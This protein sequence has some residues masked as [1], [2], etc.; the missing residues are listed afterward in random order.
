MCTYTLLRNVVLSRTRFKV[1][2]GVKY[3]PYWCIKHTPGEGLAGGYCRPRFTPAVRL[4]GGAGRRPPAPWRSGSGHPRPA[5]LAWRMVCQLDVIKFRASTN[6]LAHCHGP[7]PLDAASAEAQLQINYLQGI[8]MGQIL[9]GDGSFPFVA[10]MVGDDIIVSNVRSTWFGGPDDPTDNGET[11]SGISTVENPDLQGCALP[12]DGFNTPKTNGSP[13]PRLPW[14][15]P[16]RVTDRSSGT[17]GTFELIDLGPSKFAPSHAAIDLTEAA[18]RAL[19]ADPHVGV[20]GVDYVIVGGAKYL[21]STTQQSRS[22]F[23]SER[24]ISSQVSLAGAVADGHGHTNVKPP[25]RQFISSP[26]FSSRNGASIDMIVMHFTDGPTAQGAISRFLNPAE[27]VSAHYIIDR[28][29]SIYQMVRDSDKA[30]HAKAA[31]RTSIGIEHVSMPSWG[32]ASAQEASSIALVNWL[33]ATYR[34]P[35]ARILGHRFAPGNIGTTDCPDDLFGPA[36]EQAVT[37]WVA[38]NIIPP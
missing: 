7:V 22:L 5:F 28:D 8:A 3:S 26:N 15:L 12:M 38:K 31:N 1:D 10:E 17:S 37:D 27:Q 6:L 33:V 23:S 13:I 32:M 11:A 14:R 36:T 19:G 35:T 2:Y 21:P 24:S 30:W 16:V 34:I 25:I 20:I 4:A 29:G 9:T 18:F